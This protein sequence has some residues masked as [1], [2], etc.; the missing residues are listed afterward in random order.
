[1]N[2]LVD[3]AVVAA[4]AKAMLLMVNP[5]PRT[6]ALTSVRMLFLLTLKDESAFARTLAVS[7]GGFL[8][9]PPCEELSF[10]RARRP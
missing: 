10:R 9:P 4:S 1:M 3:P 7:H 5:R 8:T 2:P 6:A